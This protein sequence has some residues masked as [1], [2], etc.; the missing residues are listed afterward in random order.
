M[1][2]LSRIC[3]GL[4]CPAYQTFSPAYRRLGK[5]QPLVFQRWFGC[6]SKDNLKKVFNGFFCSAFYVFI[7]FFLGDRDL[8]KRTRFGT[9]DCH[10]AVTGIWIVNAYSPRASQLL[11]TAL[12]TV[13]LRL[14]GCIQSRHHTRRGT[15]YT[16]IKSSGRLLP[17][18]KSC[19]LRVKMR[20][21]MR[22]Q[23]KEESRKSLIAGWS[24]PVARQAHNLKVFS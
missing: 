19:R 24:S 6:V 16:W 7:S 2:I 3:P 21:Q 10:P 1:A 15:D 20:E 11:F 9:Y 5:P 22:E 14:L 8:L 12:A 23:S 17:G 18:V 4:T 13:T